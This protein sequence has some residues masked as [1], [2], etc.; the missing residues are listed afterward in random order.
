MDM[1]DLR[2]RNFTKET[3]QAYVISR[4]GFL[5]RQ[6]SD[7]FKIAVKSVMDGIRLFIKICR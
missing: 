4:F 5:I 6:H 1:I 2:G 7:L 3:S